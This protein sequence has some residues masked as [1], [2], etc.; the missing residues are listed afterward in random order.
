[1]NGVWMLFCRPIRIQKVLAADVCPFID[2][3]MSERCSTASTRPFLTLFQIFVRFWKRNPRN[4][5]HVML[6]F[7]STV[8]ITKPVT[9][10]ACSSAFLFGI[11]F[12]ILYFVL[13]FDLCTTSVCQ[14]TRNAHAQSVFS[15]QK[16][17]DQ[18]ISSIDYMCGLKA[19]TA[20]IITMLASS[21][22]Y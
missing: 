18:P 5:L 17:G 9:T 6:F 8:T 16:I 22:V 10:M 11:V 21:H 15:L 1:M 14:F 4:T 12:S 7:V 20:G 2:I 13:H 19:E 3:F